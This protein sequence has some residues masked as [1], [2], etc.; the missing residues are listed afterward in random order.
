[1]ATQTSDTRSEEIKVRFDTDP[2]IVITAQDALMVSQGLPYTATD[3][4]LIRGNRHPYSF[5]AGICEDCGSPMNSH[6]EC[7]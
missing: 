5:V 3:L 4:D 2:R 6:A 1:M 7:P